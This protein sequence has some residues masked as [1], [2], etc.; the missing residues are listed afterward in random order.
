M[1]FK[2][3]T[4]YFPFNRHNDHFQKYKERCGKLGIAM[5]ERAIPQ[6]AGIDR[7]FV[8]FAAAVQ[9]FLT[10][11]LSSLTQSTLDGVVSTKPRVPQFTTA[12]FLDY[13]IELVVCEDKVRVPIRR[14]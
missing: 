3:A 7:R 9:H 5:H 14:T 11:V 13:I 6:R 8:S 1:L 10:A 4:D 12:R 2:F